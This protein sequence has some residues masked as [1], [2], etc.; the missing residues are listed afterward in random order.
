[1]LILVSIG[2]RLRLGRW[3]PAAVSGAALLVGSAFPLPP[4]FNPDY[5]PFGPDKGLHLLGHAGFVALLG[6]GLGEE[7]RGIG[8]A[9]GAFVLSTVFGVTTEVLQESVSGREFERGDVIAG[10]L[11]SLLGLLA[12]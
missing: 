7:K 11:G 4:R 10:M 1:M 5:G 3:T 2:T 6:A 8:A 9:V 12:W